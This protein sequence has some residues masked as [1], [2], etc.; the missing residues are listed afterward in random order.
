MKNTRHTNRAVS[1]ARF[2]LFLNLFVL[3]DTRA[4]RRAAKRR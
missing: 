4:P 3:G 1:P 2:A